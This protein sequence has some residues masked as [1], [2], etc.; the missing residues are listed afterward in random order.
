MTVIV[1]FA[2][3]PTGRLHIGNVRTA[4]LNWLFARRHQGKFI[5][6]LDDTD[7][8]RS[9]D[10]NAEAIRTDL[11]WLGLS[12]DD[13][14]RQSDRTGRY[15]E[16]KAQLIAAGRLYPCY[17][18]EDELDRK[19]KRQMARG[20]PPL[21]DRAALRLSAD[22]RAKLAAA[23][24]RPHWRF[25][26]A[27]TGA[28]QPDTIVPTLVRWNDLVRG[29][30]AI[31]VS[32]MSDPVLARGDGSYLY[33]FTSV[34]DDIDTKI[35]HIIRG[36]DHVTNAAVQAQIFA[37]LGAEV[38][39]MAHFSLLVGREGEALSKRLGSLSVEGFRAAG[40][41]AM[42]VNSLAALIGTSDAVHPV[43]TLPELSA[44]F[45]LGKLSRSPSRFDTAELDALNAKLLHILPYADV[46][47]RLR[48]LNVDGGEPFWL[49]VRGNL[50]TLAD[51]V[52]WHRVVNGPI[53]PI[54]ENAEFT[55]AGATLLPPEPWNA[56]TWSIWTN[57]VKTATG[58]KG[59]ALFHPL[60]LALTG[61]ENGPELKVLLPLI[62]RTRALARLNGESA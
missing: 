20:L 33:T 22:E 24:T 3:S 30:Q 5:L 27:N 18:T 55:R 60:R 15:D 6:R 2:P 9:T 37:A 44:T 12:W 62:G 54:I 7:R 35:S 16:I 34:V 52:T 56:D 50:Q 14:F 57:A 25:K 51:A 41:E 8:E 49:A 61:L 29:D 46:A 40:L 4:L 47:P 32:S 31:D 17:E 36:E 1:R 53:A 10:A 21:Y 42:A 43:A 58:A 39:A 59:R 23:G 48:A 26:L 38:P 19:R 11:L 13:T 28:S 45:D